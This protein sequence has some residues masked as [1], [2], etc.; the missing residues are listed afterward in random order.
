MFLS[1]DNIENDWLVL[2]SEIILKTLVVSSD[3]KAK[4]LIKKIP[5]NP[6]VRW[7]DKLIFLF[8]FFGATYHYFFPILIMQLNT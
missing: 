3:E 8:S 2:Q 4:S 1:L 5:K 7:T 6:S